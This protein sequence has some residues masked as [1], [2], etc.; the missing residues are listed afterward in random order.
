MDWDQLLKEAIHYLQDYLRI[1]TVNPP[2]NEIEGATFFKN[3]FEKKSIPC[4]GL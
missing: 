3:I 4:S 2:G 1:E